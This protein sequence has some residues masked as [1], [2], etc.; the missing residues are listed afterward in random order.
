MSFCA[1]V[2]VCRCVWH[3]AVSG[4]CH[5][6]ISFQPQQAAAA[7]P[8][9]TSRAALLLQGTGE[10]AAARTLPQ[11]QTAAA[12][13]RAVNGALVL[14]PVVH[15]VS[16]AALPCM[17]CTSNLVKAQHSI[18]QHYTAILLPSKVAF[19]RWGQTHVVNDCCRCKHG[20]LSSCHARS[21]G[22]AGTTPCNNP[23]QQLHAG[24]PAGCCLPYDAQ[25]KS[26]IM[27]K[28]TSSVVPNA[29]QLEL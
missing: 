27:D 12:V 16:D 9:R 10:T 20:Q 5:C 26:S 23:M 18:T 15:W 6:S 1:V 17:H 3:H 4:V 19:S 14:V 7:G 11:F 21:L 8:C 25:V 28:I 22:C 29:M 24:Q 2:P 13:V